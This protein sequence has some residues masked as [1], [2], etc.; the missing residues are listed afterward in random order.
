MNAAEA[1][2]E[3]VM[4]QS[5]EWAQVVAELA[6][7]PDECAYDH[8]DRGHAAENQG[9]PGGPATGRELVEGRLVVPEDA[10]REIGV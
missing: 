8:A 2:P 3:V 5:M 4:R 10:Q 9:M 6:V 1:A 7:A